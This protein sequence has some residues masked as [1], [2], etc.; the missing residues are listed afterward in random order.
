MEISVSQFKAKCLGVVEKVQ[1][2]GCRV[3]I[4]KYGRVAAELGPAVE[5][6]RASLW[7]RSKGDTIIHADLTQTGEHRDAEH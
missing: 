6:K 7:G 3:R 2:E 1:K 5:E 4:T